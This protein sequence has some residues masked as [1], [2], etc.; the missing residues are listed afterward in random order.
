MTECLTPAARTAKARASLASAGHRKIRRIAQE[1]SEASAALF[2]LATR[3]RASWTLT[4]W[5]TLLARL[6]SCDLTAAAWLA[7]YASPDWTA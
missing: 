7:Q 4:D 6:D 5:N 1:D 2:H 3:D